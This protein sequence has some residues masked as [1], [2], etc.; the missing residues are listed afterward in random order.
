[1][2]WGG[3]LEASQELTTKLDLEVWMKGIPGQRCGSVWWENGRAQI[4]LQHTT[5]KVTWGVAGIPSGS[6]LS[7][8][9][10]V[11]MLKWAGGGEGAGRDQEKRIACH[12]EEIRLYTRGDK[13]PS[14]VPHKFQLQCG[15]CGGG[16]G[17][18]S[19]EGP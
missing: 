18:V 13:C 9:D 8:K 1:M 19:K 15:E 16:G 14:T 11:K 6:E 10:E 3:D 12:D 4:R 5:G 2:S 7:V 17:R